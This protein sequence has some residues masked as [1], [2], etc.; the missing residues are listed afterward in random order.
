MA[1]RPQSRADAGQGVL[2]DHHAGD[3]HRHR[4]RLR[5]D[6]SD[7]GVGVV[8]DAERRRRRADHGGDDA[9]GRAPRHHGRIHDHAE[10][11]AARLVRDGGD[12]RSPSWRCSDRCWSS[13][14]GGR[15]P[16]AK[17]RHPRRPTVRPC[18]ARTNDRSTRPPASAA[19]SHELPIPRAML[20][21][22]SLDI[23]KPL[24]ARDPPYLATLNAQQRVAV[25]HGVGVD[26]DDR[27]PLLIIAGAGSG[28][29]STLA[30]RAAHLIANGA[31]PQRLLLLTFSR[32][33]AEALERRAGQVL[34]RL[35]TTASMRA[36][37]ARL[38]RHVSQ[39]RRARAAPVRD[40]HRRQRIVQHSRSRGC[41][42]SA[43]SR[44]SRSRPVGDEE[45]ISGEG[46]VHRD[47]LAR[48][49]RRDVARRRSRR[50]RT[51]GARSGG[52]SWRS[53]SKPTSLRS[54]RRT[55]STTTISCST[56]PT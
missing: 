11:A 34:Q 4:D 20:D 30:C 54:R 32:R 41:R 52:A 49:Q 42:G 8:G 1:D 24:T 9:N 43:R 50:T 38:G 15:R 47:L 17:V 53:C 51:R 6:R 3:R 29:T 44:A 23:A 40:A 16:A 10:A 12:G 26:A 48:R 13:A 46:H 36:S 21:A 19:V 35:S 7:Q 14:R 27:R 37:G 33:A 5:A 31:D 45:S 22:C 56:G 39:R 55:S 28:K 2:R 25:E 18:Y